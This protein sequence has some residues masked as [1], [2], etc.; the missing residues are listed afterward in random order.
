VSALDTAP[1]ARRSSADR[2]IVAL[3]A[4]VGIAVVV[5]IVGKTY[6]IPSTV[7]FVACGIAAASAGYFMVRMIGAIRDETLDVPGRVFDEE[8]EKLE[9]EKLLLLQGIKEFEA[10]AATGKV[11]AADYEHL[12]KSAEARAVEIIRALKESDARWLREAETYVAQKLGPE[13]S[14]VAKAEAA[15]VA[16]GEPVRTVAGA[17]REDVVKAIAKMFDDRPTALEPNEGKLRCSACSTDN[18]LDARFCV[19][20]GRPRA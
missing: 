13:A 11:D 12:R 1:R 9:H 2:L 7:A 4:I 14:R 5:A 19:G 20:C 10:D 16:A 8:R 17:I 3:E 6:G 15:P 18:D